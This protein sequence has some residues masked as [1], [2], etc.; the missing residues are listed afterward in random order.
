MKINNSLYF[1]L[2]DT[3]PMIIIMATVVARLFSPGLS[4]ILLNY[5][6]PLLMLWCIFKNRSALRNSIIVL[7]IVL[8]FWTILT[9]WISDLLVNV[10]IIKKKFRKCIV[11]IGSFRGAIFQFDVLHF[12][13]RNRL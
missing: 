10:L 8:L 1:K 11:V 4:S 12:P 13:V 5:I 3:V 9:W 2:D 7:Y 6:F